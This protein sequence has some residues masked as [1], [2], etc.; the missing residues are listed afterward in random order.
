MDSTV[1]WPLRGGREIKITPKISRNIVRNGYHCKGSG[2]LI[3]ISKITPLGPK[4]LSNDF[5]VV[6]TL[7]YHIKNTGAQHSSE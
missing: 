1:R 6:N 4:Q 7:V 2:M 5:P 3:K